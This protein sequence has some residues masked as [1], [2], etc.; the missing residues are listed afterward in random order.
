MVTVVGNSIIQI[1]TNN[2]CVTTEYQTCW[3]LTTNNNS[4][5][6]IK[7]VAREQQLVPNLW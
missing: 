7:L 3:W 6:V 1:V 5:T 2:I 4:E